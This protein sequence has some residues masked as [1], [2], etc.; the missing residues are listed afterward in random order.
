M[1]NLF[2]QAITRLSSILKKVQI[3]SLISAVFLGTILLTSGYIANDG[4]RAITANEVDSEIFEGN[5]QRPTTTNEWYEE[6]NQT[7]GEPIEKAKR[8]G[9]ETGEAIKDLGKLYP[10]VA[11]RT[12]SDD[13]K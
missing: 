9:K 4:D 2:S 10:N 8:I 7:E 3:K 11:D 12:V 6:A 5:P 1:L 13:L